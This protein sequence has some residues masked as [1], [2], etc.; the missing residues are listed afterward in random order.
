[1]VDKSWAYIQHRI[2]VASLHRQIRQAEASIQFLSNRIQQEEKTGWVENSAR[3]Q[4]GYAYPGERLYKNPSLHPEG[5]KKSEKR[6][7]PFQALGEAWQA[8]KSLFSF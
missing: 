8:L 2:Q 5:E 3:E 4:Y 7:T 1:V 6:K